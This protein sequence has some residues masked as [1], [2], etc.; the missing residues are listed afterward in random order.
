[1]RSM[2]CVGMSTSSFVHGSAQSGCHGIRG[3]EWSR[4]MPPRLLANTARHEVPVVRRVLTWHS[5]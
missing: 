3:D 5:A 2:R 4:L 1:M